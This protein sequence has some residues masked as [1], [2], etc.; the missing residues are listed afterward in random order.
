LRDESAQDDGADLSATNMHG[1][2]VPIA[3]AY[4]A[5]DALVHSVSASD[6]GAPEGASEGDGAARS[7]PTQHASASSRRA[8]RTKA[9]LQNALSAH[10]RYYK[11]IHKAEY[12][13]W[14]FAYKGSLEAHLASDTEE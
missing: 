7:Q 3:E 5:V 6:D 14:P 13:C 1:E 8:R 2:R 11:N 12:G 10:W 9:Q 4:E